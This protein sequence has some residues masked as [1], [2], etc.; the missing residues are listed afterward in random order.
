MFTNFIINTYKKTLLTRH[1]PDGAIFYFSHTDF[2]GM[3]CEPFEFFGERGQRLQGYFYTKNLTRPERLVIFEHGMG[4]GHR[5]Y[6]REI[7]TLAEH[8]YAVFTY[9]HT[10]TLASGGDHIGGF[11]QSLCDLDCAIKALKASGR[12]DGKRLAVVGHSWGGFSTMNIGAFHRDVTHLVAMSGFTSPINIITDVIGKLKKYAPAI[13]KSEVEYFGGYAY[14]NSSLSL[15]ETDAKAL[16][17]HSE[18][19]PTV[20]YSQFAELRERLEGIE[21]I[22]FMSLNGK[23]HNPNYTEDAVRYKDVFFAELTKFRKKKNITKE[24][25]SAFVRSWDWYKMTEQDMDFWGRVFE[26]IDEEN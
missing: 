24:E 3:E 14:A 9:D 15:L 10:G 16:I 17:V 7:V 12:A 25:K 4:C 20:P 6:M 22:S 13:L 26:F 8:G 11:T 23:K 21:R 2:L 1:D 5:A 19:D 18:D